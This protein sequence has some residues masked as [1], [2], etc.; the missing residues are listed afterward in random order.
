MY[1][2]HL[3]ITASSVGRASDYRFRAVGSNPTVG[4]N[5]SFSILSLNWQVDW[6][7][8]NEIKHDFHPRY[9]GA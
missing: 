6:F 3:N 8:T 9:I 4:K 7:H 1:K 5:F 2:G